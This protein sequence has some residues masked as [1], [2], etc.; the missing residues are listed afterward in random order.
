MKIAL[1]QLNPTVGDFEGNLSLVAE[2]LKSAAEAGAELAVFPE[3]FL[4]GYPPHDLLE[5]DW[6]IER[7]E[8]ALSNAAAASRRFPGTAVLLG[9]VTR[10]DRPAG[11]GLHNSAVLLRDG[12]TLATVHKALLPTYDVFDEARYFDPAEEL[13]PVPL[14]DEV[15]GISICEDAWNVPSLGLRPP[16]AHDPVAEL[17]E[18]GVTLFVNISASPFYVGKDRLRYDLF[19]AHASR[20]G[21]P[22][23]VVNQVGGN[24][25]LVFDGRSAAV[26]PDGSLLAYCPSFEE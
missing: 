22:F 9:T 12:D 2:A 5:R 17:A 8:A 1:C 20:H 24:D 11:K 15:L 14:G 19:S 25:E 4:T 26:A 13:H 18:S 16:Y 10:S 7:A 23:V 3:M 21:A 6:F